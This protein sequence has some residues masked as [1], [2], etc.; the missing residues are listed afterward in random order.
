[1]G[2]RQGDRL[3][4]H[5]RRV[6]PLEVANEG[7]H[8]WLVEGDPTSNSVTEAPDDGR[9]VIGEAVGGR[10]VGPTTF[11]LQRLRQVPVV[12]RRDGCDAAS[13][14][15]VDQPVVEIEP[16]RV[17]VAAVGLHPGPRD[18]KAVGLQ[19]ELG[20]QIQ[21]AVMSPVSP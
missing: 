3:V 6:A 8:P 15:P 1:M 7:G 21:I 5:A 11:I 4:P 18:G 17:D 14:E 10:P 16:D 19:P 12:E 20:H 13:E 2:S 9:R